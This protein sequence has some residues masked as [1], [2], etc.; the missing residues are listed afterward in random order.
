MVT[1]FLLASGLH[2][3]IEMPAL[4]RL[5]HVRAERLAGFWSWSRKRQRRQS[6]VGD[7]PQRERQV[8][9]SCPQM[10]RF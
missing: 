5:R 9:L 3:W 1:V 10:L 2:R 8:P 6:G 7:S 4:H